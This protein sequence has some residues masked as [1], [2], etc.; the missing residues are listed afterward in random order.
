MF[1]LPF[2]LSVH[3]GGGP[4]VGYTV[5]DGLNETI[6]I[7]RTADRRGYNRFWMSEHHAM[8]ALSIASPTVMIARLTAETER[9]RLGAG[10]IMLPNHSPLVIAEEYG[11]LDALAPGRIDLGLGRAPGTDAMTAAALRRGVDANEGFPQ[12]L[13]ELMGFL[14][15]NFPAGH[16]YRDVHA[17]PGPWQAK[18]NRV[19]VPETTPELWILGS[20]TYSAHLAARLGRPYAF[21]LQFGNADVETAMRIYREEFKPSDVL[22]SPYSMVS[23]K[24]V[25]ADDAETARREATTYA[26]AML[27]MLSRAPFAVF[28]PEEVESYPATANEQS[29][30]DMYTNRTIA[31]TAETVADQLDQLQAH[32]G[33]DEMMMVLGTHTP[34]VDAHGLELLADHYNL[35]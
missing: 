7:A 28:S 33:V 19:A 16:P 32:T 15:D 2:A 18:Q 8:P 5:E 26:M 21:A 1:D 29:I 20:S 17:V 24:T 22:D 14:G 12:Q 3:T 10:G 9:I 34:G 6:E 11:M 4:G 31:G 25:I 13:S 35:S 23:V 30:I 27:R